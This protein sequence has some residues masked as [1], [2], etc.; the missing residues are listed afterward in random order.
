MKMTNYRKC[1]ITTETVQNTL[2]TAN[3]QNKSTQEFL[4]DINLDVETYMDALQ[5]SQRGPNIILKGNPQ[6]VL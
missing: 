3:V 4:Q 6:D 5:I 1:K 2:P